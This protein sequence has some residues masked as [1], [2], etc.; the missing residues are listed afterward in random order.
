MSFPSGERLWCPVP[1]LG[2]EG[3]CEDGYGREQVW[4]FCWWEKCFSLCFAVVFP[5]VAGTMCLCEPCQA[6]RAPAAGLLL[7]AKIKKGSLCDLGWDGRGGD[8][9]LLWGR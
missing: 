6:A 8:E 9:V 3:G 4:V 2:W 7:P 5:S 1:H